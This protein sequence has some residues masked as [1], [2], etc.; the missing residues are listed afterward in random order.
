MK[1][2]QIRAA[3]D[4]DDAWRLRPLLAATLLR[5][6]TESNHPL[7]SAAREAPDLL[8]RIE[9]VAELAGRAAHDDGDD[10]FSLESVDISVQETLEIVGL[11]LS[12]P[13]EPIKEVLR[14]GQQEQ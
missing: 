2:G 8:D 11:L 12:L 3:S 6:Q 5:A 7:R 4:Y 14:D 9:R 13:V 1:H 10:V